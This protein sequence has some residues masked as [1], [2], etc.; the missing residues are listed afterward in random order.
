MNVWSWDEFY[1]G[2]T[3]GA[4]CSYLIFP[5]GRVAG[6]WIQEAD[7][8]GGSP[9]EDSPTLKSIRVFYVIHY[10]KTN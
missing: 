3:V 5:L 4:K 8:T 2:P 1:Q 7:P 9:A 6:G 10:I